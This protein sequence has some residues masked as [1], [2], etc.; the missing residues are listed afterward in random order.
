VTYTAEAN[1]FSV[2]RTATI[3]IAGRTFTL[4]QQGAPVQINIGSPTQTVVVTGESDSIDLAA[5]A[6]MFWVAV[7]NDPWIVI[8][9]GTSGHG[10]G[11]ITFQASANRSVHSRSTTITITGQI[12]APVGGTRMAV[13][14]FAAGPVVQVITITQPGVVG[15][16]T[17]APARSTA[18]VGA[19]AGSIQVRSNATDFAWSAVSN[20]A[21]LTVT[22]GA[23]GMGDGSVAFSVAANPLQ[24]SR[25]GTIT[26]ANQV[27]T[28]LQN[29]PAAPT[30][31][32]ES[33]LLRF[34]YEVGG[35]LPPVQ[36][37]EVVSVSPSVGISATASAPWIKVGLSSPVTPSRLRIGVL[38]TGMAPGTYYGTVGMPGAFEIQI[39]LVVAPAPRL[40]ATPAAVTFQENSGEQVVY[41]TAGDRPL[42]FSIRVPADAKWLQVLVVNDSKLAPANLRL[43]ANPAGLAPGTYQTAV[44]ILA[45]EAANSPLVVPLTLTIGTR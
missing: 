30:L 36:E 26:V 43:R 20:A 40:R 42:P 4:T 33:E 16:V 34:R 28:L 9:A 6:D 12:A 31:F 19:S 27:F 41:F 10:N 44:E 23:S 17:L 1:P 39:T 11:R 22:S 15:A 29:G 24:S 25:T 45:P 3:T 14:P 37:V 35:T 8:T 32:L 18:S 7:S 38:P 13:R 21:W 2:P 5:P